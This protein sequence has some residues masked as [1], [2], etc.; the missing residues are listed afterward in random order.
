MLSLLSRYG[1][2]LALHLP[3]PHTSGYAH[4]LHPH[5][6]AH[7]L[8][9]LH[10][11]LL[12]ELGGGRL[13]LHFSCVKDTA[14]LTS[15]SSSPSPPP[16]A[17]LA[18]LRLFA[19]YLSAEELER[20]EGWTGGVHKGEAVYGKALAEE[21]DRFG[22]PSPAALPPSLAALTLTLSTHSPSPSPSPQQGE[23][24]WWLWYQP[25]S[26][27]LPTSLP[28]DRVS[29]HVLHPGNG[30]RPTL[31]DPALYHPTLALLTLHS[32]TVVTLTPLPPSA[33][34]A[35]PS[36]TPSPPLSIF[37]PRNSLLYL[38]PEVT[39][40]FRYSVPFRTRDL[41]A[42]EKRKRERT[43]LLRFTSVLL[44]PS[45]SL[46]S[47]LPPRPSSSSTTPALLPRQTL[48]TPLPPSLTSLAP[49]L[50][51]S[52]HVHSVY[53]RIATHFSHTRHS[54][55]PRVE[56][57]LLSLPPLT[58][59]ADVGCG[60][61][62]YMGVNRE[63]RMKG[64][65]L[66]RGLVEIARGR[67]HDVEVMD[68]MEL[69][70][71]GD[72][73][74][75][76]LSVAVLHHVGSVERRVRML[77]EM[78]RVC[79]VGGEVIVTAWA[80]EQDKGSRRRFEQQDVLVP[81]TLPPAFS[82]GEGGKGGGG[83]GG[84]GGGAQGRKVLRER[85]G[86]KGGEE[87][88]AR[89]VEEERKRDESEVVVQRYCHVYVEGELEGLFAQVPHCRVVDRYYDRG[90]WVVVAQKTSEH[91]PDPPRI[92]RINTPHTR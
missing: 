47:P 91:E 42:R 51:E 59:V 76:V 49:H 81:W 70:W 6:A 38:P 20:V 28:F 72:E 43:V 46:S 82:E 86:G 66:A 65:D 58:S 83:G 30:L 10:L 68:A 32:H 4:F 26:T 50:L 36:P 7:A 31:H 64:C 16:P 92:A 55:W 78:V 35:T 29:V 5:H 62:K 67:G 87:G 74:D 54:P 61:G 52:L 71:G 34:A 45:P 88:R 2:I 69:G 3:H 14:T 11:R 44:S 75:V 89:E 13:S 90:N 21:D 24:A 25:S 84:D 22:L 48:A 9:S 79:R 80:Q 39:S 15:V 8:S 85:G 73:F 37:L 60:N 12:P 23:G 17:S 53:E 1:P 56:R 33:P 41:M 19:P 27:S 77:G 40:A 57:Y 18:A 63:L